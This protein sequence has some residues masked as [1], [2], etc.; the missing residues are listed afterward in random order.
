VIYSGYAVSPAGIGLEL[1]YKSV[2]QGHH[3]GIKPMIGLSFPIVSIMYAYNFDFYK[4]KE[5]RL[6]QHEIILGFRLA[7]KRLKK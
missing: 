2:A 1:N 5:E 4:E 6:S 3:F 7:F